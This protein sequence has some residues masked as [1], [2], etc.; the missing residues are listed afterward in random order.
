[1]LSLGVC[2]SKHP[3]RASTKAEAAAQKG[4]TAATGNYFGAAALLKK[5]HDSAVNLMN[6]R[7]FKKIT[8]KVIAIV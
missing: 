7:A 1:M 8:E 6:Y 5:E 2:Y 4:L 3:E